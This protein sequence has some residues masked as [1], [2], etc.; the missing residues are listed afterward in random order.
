MF[1]FSLFEQRFMCRKDITEPKKR[2]EIKEKEK[3]RNG[4]GFFLSIR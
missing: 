3:S 4:F 2:Q 1:S